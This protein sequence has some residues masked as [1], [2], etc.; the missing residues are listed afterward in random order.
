MHETSAIRI[1]HHSAGWYLHTT[2]NLPRSYQRRCASPHIYGDSV[3]TDIVTEHQSRQMFARWNATRLG[4][5][6]PDAT[7]TQVDGILGSARAAGLPTEPL[8][9]R[10]LEVHQ[11]AP[12]AVARRFTRQ[13]D[14]HAMGAVGAATISLTARKRTPTDAAG[15]A[16]WA[17]SRS[18]P[19]SGLLQRSGMLDSGARRT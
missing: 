3:Y 2:T 19:T 5:S 16:P 8:I 7:R 10:A 4:R 18:Y 1:I 11:P 15:E 13:Q 17:I 14:A 6:L 9:D 12:S